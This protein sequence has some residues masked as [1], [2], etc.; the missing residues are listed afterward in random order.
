MQDE[1]NV[2]TEEASTEEQTSTETESKEDSKQPSIEEQIT[3]AMGEQVENMSRKIQ[4]ATDKAIGQIRREADSTAKI[5]EDALATMD[6][7]FADDAEETKPKPRRQD[8][9]RSQLD[10]RRQQ[11]AAVKQTVDAFESNIRQHIVDLGIDPEDKSI[12]W[13]DSGN[14][15]LTD[16]QGKI[17]ASVSK[18]QKDNVKSADDKRKQEFT[19]LE[20]KLRKDLGLDSVDTTTSAGVASGS[21]DDFIEKMTSG[22]LPLTE[23]NEKRFNKIQGN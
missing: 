9:F 1:K 7:T 4:S 13:G 18:I 12:D 5:A 6:A 14:L 16:R 19:E 20:A 17:L 22:E 2:Q 11:E 23:A 8:Q 15:S 10:Q 21:D 3:K